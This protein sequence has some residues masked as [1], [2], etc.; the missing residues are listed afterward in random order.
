MRECLQ[1]YL[2]CLLDVFYT[3]S[4]RL[5]AGLFERLLEDGDEL[6]ENEGV[7]E[8][9]FILR[10]HRVETR[11][12]LLVDLAVDVEIEGLVDLVDAQLQIVVEGQVD[13]IQALLLINNFVVEVLLYAVEA[14]LLFGQEAADVAQGVVLSYDEGLSRIVGVAQAQS[15]VQVWAVSGVGLGVPLFRL[16]KLA[17]QPPCRLVSAEAKFGRA[18]RSRPVS[19]CI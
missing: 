10:E 4:L 12:V 8:G 18:W 13:E 7:V 5:L 6:I 11:I 19:L 9:H 2:D 17:L 14:R 1:R 3:L 16:L 15:D